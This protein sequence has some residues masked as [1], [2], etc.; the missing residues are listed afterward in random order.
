MVL[1]K[2]GDLFGRIVERVYLNAVNNK[3][4]KM[5]TI[6]INILESR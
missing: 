6:P 3:V 1:E 2:S 4:N 5:I